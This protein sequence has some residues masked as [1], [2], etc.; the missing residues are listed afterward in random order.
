MVTGS[1]LALAVSS[2]TVRRF[3]LYGATGVPDDDPDEVGL[4]WA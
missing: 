4:R 2:R 3:L 1:G